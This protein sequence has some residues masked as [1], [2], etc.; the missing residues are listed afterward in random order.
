MKMNKKFLVSM[1]GSV[2]VSCVFAQSSYALDNDLTIYAWGAGI[3]GTATI[4]DQTPAQ[5]PTEVDFE[6][7]L[8]NLE[9]AFMGHYEGMG[10]QWGFG[11][12]LT[13]IG[14]GN[15][16]DM[17]VTGDVDASIAE[18]FAIYRPNDIF[19]VLAGVR[20]IGLDMR[21]ESQAGAVAEGDR[22]LT[23]FYLGGRVFLPFS[24]TWGGA[25]RADV[26]TGDS[27]LTWN[28]VALVNWQASDGFAV[29]GGYR[30]LDY[31]VDKDDARVSNELDLTFDGPFLG[32]AFQ[33]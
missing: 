28:A 13:Y 7:I 9:M 17:G 4:N 10:D 32:V 29:R 8:D 14:L 21:V 15:T 6:D 30:W 18:V 12:D 26:G 25:L 24:D 2:A 20:N 1:I 27:D 19:D 11:A 3:T 33:W 23:D 22:S 5:A 31:N 16:N